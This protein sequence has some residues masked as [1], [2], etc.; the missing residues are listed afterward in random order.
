[1]IYQKEQHSKKKKK[2]KT[3]LGMCPCQDCC[4]LPVPGIELGRKGVLTQPA[5]T[6]VKNTPPPPTVVP[7]CGV[8]TQPQHRGEKYPPPCLHLL[9]PEDGDVVLCCDV[10]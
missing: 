8:L 4:R 9:T 1:M 3:R 2:E 6:E 5:N 10:L 7:Y